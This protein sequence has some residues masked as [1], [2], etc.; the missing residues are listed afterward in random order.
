MKK[1]LVTGGA[2]FIGSH[3]VVELCEAGYTPIIVDNFSNSHPDV[4][5]GLAAI[6]EHEV[7]HY[8]IDCTNEAAVE[9]VFEQE[10]PFFGIIH[11]AAFKAV[12]DSVRRPLAYYR[13]NLLSTEVLLHKMAAHNC[14]RLVFSS[15]C[16]V[17]GQPEN[18]PVTEQTKFQPASSPYGYTKQVCEQMI[19]DVVASKQSD[20]SAV[21]LRYFNP[22]GAHPSGEIGELPIGVPENLIPYITQT[23]AGK[24]AE[25]IVFGN[26]YET[27][28]GTCV[29]D[30]IHVVDLAKAHVAA[31]EWVQNHTSTCEAFN[32][33][34]GNGNTVKEVIDTFTE[35]TGVHVAHRI[36]KR[37]EGDVVKIWASPLKAEKELG[38][39]T[40]LSL[41]QALIDAWNWEKKLT[42]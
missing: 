34:T 30:Y 36:G 40:S 10:G 21:L 3:T 14:H 23:A 31:L 20:F 18:L 29:R 27:L 33:G 24:R 39:K 12:G 9:A 5:K 35:A 32:L 19:T 1:V 2:G 4:L 17:Y 22:I 41:K 15:S 13:N 6:L 11:F 25:L 37:R 42:K 26:D 38:W 28:D 8:A 7:K 16:T